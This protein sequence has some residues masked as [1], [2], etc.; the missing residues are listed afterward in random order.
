MEAIR[1]RTLREAKEIF[2]KEI[3]R[4]IGG[5]ESSSFESVIS[6]GREP[7]RGIGHQPGLEAERKLHAGSGHR[8]RLG[9]KPPMRR[10]AIESGT[11]KVDYPPVLPAGGIPAG[12]P[13]NAGGGAR[14]G[15]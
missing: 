5:G 3:K 14:D 12:G 10:T 9:P 6:A 11:V 15:A 2:V 1:E 13:I 4:V 8:G 7:T